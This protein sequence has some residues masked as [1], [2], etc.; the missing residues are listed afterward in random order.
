MPCVPSTSLTA[1]VFSFVHSLNKVHCTNQSKS[2]TLTSALE[3]YSSASERV[4]SLH[5]R[6]QRGEQLLGENEEACV[7]L[8]TQIGQ[9]T[10]ISHQHS[11]LVVKQKDKIRHLNKVSSLL[12]NSLLH[13]IDLV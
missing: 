9:D 11:G 3:S 2:A 1:P 7:K 8:I 12:A 13:V 6:Q 4:A 10:A 5:E